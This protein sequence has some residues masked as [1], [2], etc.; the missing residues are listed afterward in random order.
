MRLLS[1]Q[2]R[3]GGL[4][5]EGVPEAC[6][7]LE[8]FKLKSLSAELDRWLASQNDAGAAVNTNPPC[9]IHGRESLIFLHHRQ[10]KLS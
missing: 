5:R 4:A 2:A 10:V 3:K 9:K 8:D 6:A 7:C 1:I